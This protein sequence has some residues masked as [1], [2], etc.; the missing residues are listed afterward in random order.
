MFDFPA[1]KC[2]KFLKTRPLGRVWLLPG[3]IY[4]KKKKEFKD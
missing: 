1:K 3:K 4:H 2:I